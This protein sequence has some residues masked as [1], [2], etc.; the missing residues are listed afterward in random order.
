MMIRFACTSGG[1]AN[2]PEKQLETIATVG[3]SPQP[4]LSAAS[5]ALG[6]NTESDSS[7]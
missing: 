6:V 1:A 7:R 2:C 4:F 3:A 5:K